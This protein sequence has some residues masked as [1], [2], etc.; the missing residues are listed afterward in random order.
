MVPDNTL[1]EI[2]AQLFRI[3]LAEVLSD[4]KHGDHTHFELVTV[5]VRLADCSIGTDYAYTG[6]KGGCAILAMIEHDLFPFCAGGIGPMSKRSM[7]RCNGMCIMWRAVVSC[8]L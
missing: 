4:A 1:A 5:T 2:D 6:G 3:P 7:M 8:L